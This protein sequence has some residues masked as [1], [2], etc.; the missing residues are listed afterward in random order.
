MQHGPPCTLPG[1]RGAPARCA[2]LR[3]PPPPIPHPL[4]AATFSL[5]T[6]RLRILAGRFPGACR[7]GD[8]PPGIKVIGFV[9]CAVCMYVGAVRLC[10]ASSPSW[11]CASLCGIFWLLP[12]GSHQSTALRRR[13]CVA[14][15]APRCP[16]VSAEQRI[17]YRM[18]VAPKHASERRVPYICMRVRRARSVDPC[19]SCMPDGA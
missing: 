7:H 14:T 4:H 2:A 19:R 15:H 8:D 17:Y 3:H 1:P 16:V 11:I 18:C 13:A 10:D 5:R 6:R 12:I 9:M